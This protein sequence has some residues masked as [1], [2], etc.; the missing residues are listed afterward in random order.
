MHSR[1]TV[2]LDNEL[3]EKVSALTEKSGK[4]V[5]NVLR[6]ALILYFHIR[7]QGSSGV[8]ES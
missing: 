5:S 3:L 8:E 1:V 2:R 7:A 4:N 6:E